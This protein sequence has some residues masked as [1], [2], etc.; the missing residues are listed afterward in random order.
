MK[1][2]IVDL[3]GDKENLYFFEDKEGLDKALVEFGK[4]DRQKGVEH[5]G[6]TAEMA[7]RGFTPLEERVVSL[8]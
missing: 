1:V 8:G 3:Y 7:K 4:L 6:F 5:D 2:V